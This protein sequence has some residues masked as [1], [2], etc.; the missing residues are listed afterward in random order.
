[1]DSL[2]A[3]NYLHFHSKFLVDMLAEMLGGI[4]AAVLATSAT[5]AEHQ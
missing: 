1:M 5:E 3:V 4:H 2:F